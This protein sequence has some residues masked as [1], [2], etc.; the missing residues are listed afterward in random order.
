ME[1][2]HCK[3]YRD[4]AIRKGLKGNSVYS[5]SLRHHSNPGLTLNHV[6]VKVNRYGLIPRIV[7]RRDSGV[8]WVER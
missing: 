8:G 7:L 4:D 6:G 1:A 5:D 3:A 2:I